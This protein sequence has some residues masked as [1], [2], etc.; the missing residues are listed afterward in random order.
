VEFLPPTGQPVEPPT[1]EGC[2]LLQA[3]PDKPPI[4]LGHLL[5]GVPPSLVELSGLYR[6]KVSLSMISERTFSSLCFSQLFLTSA[7]FLRKDLAPIGVG[8]NADAQSQG[9]PQQRASFPF[10]R[11]DDA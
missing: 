5:L 1:N 9:F 8:V 4:P 10:C 3:H 11:L 7:L 2:V 6:D